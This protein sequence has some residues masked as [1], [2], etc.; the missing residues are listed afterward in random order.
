MTADPLAWRV[1][2]ACAAAY[3][4]IER[5][6][7]G[8]WWVARSGG[9]SRRINAASAAAPRA[10]LDAATLTAIDAH[11]DAVGLP[12]IVRVTDLAPAASDLLDATGFAAPEGAT[13]TLLRAPGNI[14]ADRETIVSD[15]A[16]P[17]WL[18]ARR[19]FAPGA[20]DP[21]AIASR[22]R[23]PAAYAHRREQGA[24]RSIGY[25]ALH[26]G[27]AVIEAIATDPTAR[28]RGHAR[29]IVA[30]LI[31]WATRHGAEHIALQVE[32]TNAPARA[33]YADMAFATDLY[34]YHY[35]RSAPCPNRG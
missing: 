35:R 24:I 6:R 15:R 29:A 28:R 21:A 25:V 18:A 3:P 1:E 23:I 5:L 14:D 34:G 31:D 26:D 2:Q 27:I 11:Y 30:T 7:V 33:L 10:A 9:G 8:D 13:R 16:V 22:L 32:E 17:D 19:R 4:P 12:T 20:T